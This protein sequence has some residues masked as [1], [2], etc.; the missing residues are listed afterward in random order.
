MEIQGYFTQKGLE[1]SAK[2][3]TGASLEITRVVAG[4]GQ[5]ADL[6]SAS[7][8]SQT[9]Q[10][11][12][13]NTPTRSGNTATIP[14]TLAAA[15]ATANYTLSELG[16]YA[17]DP[18]KGEI[19]YKV[20][21]LDKP[22]S[23]TAG[24]RMVLRFYLEET[25]S[26]DLNV[27]VDCSPDGL[28]TEEMFEPVRERV[29]A[30]EVP[31]V[32]VSLAASELQGYLN[33]LPRLVTE[34]LLIYVSGEINEPVTV[35][36]FYGSGSV[37]I[38]SQNLGD[39]VFKSTVSIVNCH[40]LVG[41]GKMMWAPSAQTDGAASAMLSV[42][43]SIM[44][45][46]DNCEFSGEASSWNAYGVSANMDSAVTMIDCSIHHIARAVAAISGGKATVH[47]TNAS[48][49]HDNTYGAYV[50]TGG[51]IFLCGSVPDILGGTV[52]YKNGGLIVKSDGTLL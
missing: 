20:Y 36:D 3:L 29:L 15:L 33:S 18:D 23:I 2:L 48:A 32:S 5:T 40:V 24:S 19:L 41:L 1:L 11:L 42:S 50:S 7:S 31:T 12:A 44:V 17:R 51:M 52:N 43:R 37:N 9:K 13:V 30:K 34:T 46:T 38:L 10:T 26:Q 45:R 47:G 14:A 28:I 21:R 16:V 35:S 49:F 6:A 25:V 39:A 4:S 8:L 22:V 27:T